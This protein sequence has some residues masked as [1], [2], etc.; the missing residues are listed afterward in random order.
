[1]LRYF[2]PILGLF[3]IEEFAE[4]LVDRYPTKK[5]SVL[6]FFYLVEHFFSILFL[7]IYMSIQS[8]K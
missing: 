2:I 1:M 8:S 5:Q 7:I 3:F 6:I 4:Y